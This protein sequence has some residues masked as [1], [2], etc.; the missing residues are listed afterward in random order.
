MGDYL[1]PGKIDTIVRKIESEIGRELRY[2]ICD[3]G[4]FVYRLNAY[5][6]F[7]R[8]ILDYPHDK[9]IDKIGLE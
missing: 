5:D 2:S 8:D 4:D 3:T 9:V 6:K 1:K 7:V